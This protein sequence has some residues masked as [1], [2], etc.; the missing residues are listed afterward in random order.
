MILWTVNP[1]LRD[2]FSDHAAGICKL[3]VAKP[4]LR[5]KHAEYR[6]LKSIDITKLKEDIPAQFSAI[7]IKT[8][9][10]I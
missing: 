2:Y 4:L 8:R 10:M 5:I 9:L 3:I 1:F 6:K 7:S